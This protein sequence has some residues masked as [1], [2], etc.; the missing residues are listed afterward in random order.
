MESGNPG[1]LIVLALKR[2]GVSHLFTLNGAHTLSALPPA[3]E[4]GMRV[5]DT[6]HEQSAAFAAEGWA[7]VTRQCG[8]AAVTAGPGVTNSITT[9]AQAQAGDTPMFVIGGRAPNA[10][11]GMGSLQ[12][13]DHIA[14]V[15]TITKQAQTLGSA[16][17]AYRLAAESMR[18]SL[19][20][21]TGPVFMDVPLDVFFGAADMPE[22]TEHLTADPGASPDPDLIQRAAQL[23]REAQ[24][25][26]VIA[27]GTVWWSH[28]ETELKGLVEA[29]HLPLSVNGMARGMLPPGHPL[30]FPRAR[31]PALGEADLIVVIGVPP[32]F[33][34]NFGQPPVFAE[35][36]KLVVIDV[37]DHRKH[38]KSEVAIY[39]DLKASLAALGGAAAA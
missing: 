34:L 4:M 21:R 14:L 9:L 1:E 19:S 22:A 31:G 29:A 15:Q 6:R 18:A 16:E 26:S 17:E 28:A 33:R 25:P 36:A 8:V 23:I 39:G 5:I 2:S 27:G 35:G 13:M 10:R 12:E 38:R 3:A 11:W 32:A 30:F 20:G 24:R 37:D 7:K